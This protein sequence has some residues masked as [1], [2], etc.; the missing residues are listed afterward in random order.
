M[1]ADRLSGLFFVAF[2]VLLYLVIIPWQVETVDYG[3]LKPRTLPRI[4]AVILGLCGVVLALRPPGDTAHRD[5]RWARA[6]VFACVLILSLGLM[7]QLG[8][9]FVAPAM[10]LAI[11]VLSGER[12]PKWLALGVVGM[13]LLIW[14]VVAQLLERPLP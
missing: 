5:T 3:W 9:V 6:A 1:T 12:R 2:G 13:P 10:A 14:L 8:F 11:M 4:L 7:A